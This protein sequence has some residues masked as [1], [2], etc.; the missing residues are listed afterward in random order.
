MVADRMQIRIEK[1]ENNATIRLAGVLDF[2]AIAD[3]QDAMLPLLEEGHDRVTLDL[4]Q[5]SYLDSAGLNELL[6]VNRRMSQAERDWV[7][8]VT[9]ERPRRTTHMKQLLD[10]LPIK[11]A[12]R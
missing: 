3:F 2:S 5:V 7:I 9:T 4:R 12:D 11:E 1:V 10:Y 8:V 6:C